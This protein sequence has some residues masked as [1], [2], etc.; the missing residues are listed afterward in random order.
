MTR[1]DPLPCDPAHPYGSPEH[2][3]TEEQ[4]VARF[5]FA[6]TLRFYDADQAN[7]FLAGLLD[8]W[9]ES[10]CSLGWPGWDPL[11]VAKTRTF[12]CLW[13]DGEDEE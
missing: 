13:V 3:L 2:S 6:I 4:L 1:P 8:G 10:C 12:A 7:A 11:D 5:P 9:G